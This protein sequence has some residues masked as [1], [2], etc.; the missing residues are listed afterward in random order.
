[1]TGSDRLTWH[2]TTVQGRRAV[3]G[4]AGEGPALVFLH[5]WGLGSHAYKRGLSRL[6]ALGLRV[7][8]PALPGFGGTDDLPELSLEAYAAWV[9]D[10]L[11]AVDLTGPVTLVGHSFGGG[12]AI[13]TAHDLPGAVSRL[14]VVNSVGG[15]VWTADRGVLRRLSERPLW[16]WGLHLPRD[17]WPVRQATRVLPV[18]VEDALPNVL[19]NP[20]ALWRV[21]RLAARAD[22]VAELEELK[23]RGLPVV[24]LWGSADR[25]VPLACLSQLRAVLGDDQVHTVDGSHSWLLADPDGFAEVMTNVL[26]LPAAVEDVA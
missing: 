16:D 10:L 26:E 6:T 23:R 8:A 13:Q 25:L 1:M 19:R 17:V 21:G 18:I 12:V 3:Y 22:L 14:V 4:T 15:S 2:R 7:V 24:V 20:R 9:G 5:G 11:D